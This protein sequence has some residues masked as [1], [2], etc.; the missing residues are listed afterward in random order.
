MSGTALR[1]IGGWVL[2]VGLGTLALWL[3]FELLA[4]ELLERDALRSRTAG[5]ETAGLRLR[6]RHPEV[7]SRSQRTALEQQLA[8]V[9]AQLREIE[10]SSG[11][12]APRLPELEALEDRRN[13]WAAAYRHQKAGLVARF[14]EGARL[15]GRS[16]PEEAT[17]IETVLPLYPWELEEGAVP[18]ERER[19]VLTERLAFV[20]AVL[21]AASEAE[22]FRLENVS[23]VRPTELRIPD[24]VGLRAVPLRIEAVGTMEQYEDLLTA[25]L[26][27]DERPVTA[28]IEGERI[29]R[30]ESGEGADGAVAPIRVRLDLTAIVPR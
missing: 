24:S 8:D 26:K 6:N 22:M 14:V 28:T 7:P 1:L 18:A 12:V 10:E 29:E 4:P 16:G 27:N 5:I 17:L 23:F 30:L 15:A 21:V 13:E 20:E 3:L 25:L 11:V 2:A 9:E 19:E